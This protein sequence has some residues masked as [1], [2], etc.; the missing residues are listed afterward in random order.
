MKIK[1]HITGFINIQL[2]LL[3]TALTVLSC[4]NFSSS[5]SGS[6]YSGK[7]IKFTGSIVM[8]DTSGAVPE[9]IQNLFVSGGSDSSERSATVEPF[10]YDTTKHYYYAEATLR[11]KGTKV[12][13]VTWDDSHTTFSMELPDYGTWDVEVG[14]KYSTENKIIY[15]SKE[16]VEIIQGGPTS[17]SKNFI[18]KPSQTSDGQGTLKLEMTITDDC[19]IEFAE[20]SFL[21][22][23]SS[24]WN[25]KFSSSSNSNIFGVS[26]SKITL[27]G[28]ECNLKSGIY[29][30]QINFYDYESYT[31][32]N[33]AGAQ[34]A[35][36]NGV[37]VLVYSTIQTLN[38]YDNLTT[39]RWFCGTS[40]TIPNATPIGVDEPGTFKLS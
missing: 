19:S 36:E 24:S 4:T 17:Y 26:D 15:S 28:D 6:R 27:G 22:G 3:C 14:I 40:D 30:V 23:D 25:N 1:K 37:A 8:E 29:T 2:F 7:K 18:A 20:I 35:I 9:E 13:D 21:N 31:D 11:G 16:P 39:N 38:I 33:K 10:V 12:T 34:S 32:S 5:D